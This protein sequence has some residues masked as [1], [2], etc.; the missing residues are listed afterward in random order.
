MGGRGGEDM[1]QAT[2][3]V[4]LFGTAVWSGASGSSA[5]WLLVPAFFWASLNVSNRSYDRVIAANREGQMG[6]MPGLIAAGMIVAMVF[7]L[8]VRWIAQLVAG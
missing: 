6:V 4:V 5:W 2:I 7:G 3:F 8:I 1:L